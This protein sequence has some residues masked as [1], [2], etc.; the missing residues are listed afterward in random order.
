MKPMTNA[1]I[2]RR[3]AATVARSATAG[4]AGGTP[5][6]LHPVAYTGGHA[7]HCV[8]RPTASAPA[9][10]VN[11]F[12]QVLTSGSYAECQQFLAASGCRPMA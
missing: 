2:A 10:A 7:I 11:S 3:D 1:E 6:V 8:G 12:G 4:L 5:P 9:Q